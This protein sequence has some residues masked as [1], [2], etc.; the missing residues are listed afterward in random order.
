MRTFA[1]VT[2]T[3]AEI[4]QSEIDINKIC[5]IN[6]YTMC[7]QSFPD[8]FIT[9]TF[10]DAKKIFVNLFHNYSFTHYHFLYD[11]EKK[12]ASKVSSRVLTCTKKNFP[13]KCF[14]NDE[15]NEIYSFYRQGQAFIIAA[16]DTEKYS[17]DRM[18]EMDLGQMYLIYQ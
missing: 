7:N 5:G 8:P 9:C 18:T 3:E 4:A 1:K 15:K 10:L 16:N 14:Y 17:F 2:R 6:N 13:Y 12:S 11:L